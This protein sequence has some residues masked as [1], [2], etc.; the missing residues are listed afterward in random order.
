MIEKV[1]DAN[2][3]NYKKDDPEYNLMFLRT[4]EVYFND[5]LT[6]K[7]HP[8][9][10]GYVRLVDVLTEIGFGPDPIGYISGWMTGYECEN[11]VI[12][13]GIEEKEDGSISLNFNDDLINW[14]YV[15]FADTCISKR[16]LK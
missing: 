1:F 14:D 5:L 11:T 16:G 6:S 9:G 2:N 12:D 4:M 10:R 13:F 15:M 3:M 8:Y 7:R